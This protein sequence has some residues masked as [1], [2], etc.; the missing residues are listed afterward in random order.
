MH[1]QPH[2]K[3][4]GVWIWQWIKQN[5]TY[6]EL[7]ISYVRVIELGGIQIGDLQKGQLNPLRET[8]DSDRKIPAK[9]VM[10][11]GVSDDVTRLV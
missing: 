9:M 2:I 8:S 11:Q 3:L 7:N 10:K 1:G 6:E 4:Y 5:V